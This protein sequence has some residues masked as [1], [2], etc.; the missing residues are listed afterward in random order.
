MGLP[1]TNLLSQE[2]LLR[3]H[4]FVYRWG[5]VVELEYQKLNVRHVESEMPIRHNRWRHKIGSYIHRSRV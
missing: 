5:G 1:F 3:G 2:R 4:I